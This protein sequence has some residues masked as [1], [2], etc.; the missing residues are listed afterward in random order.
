MPNTVQFRG[1]ER[2]TAIVTELSERR[3]LLANR[4]LARVAQIPDYTTG[5]IA[6]DDVRQTATESLRLLVESME[7]GRARQELLDFAGSLGARRA[8]QGIPPESL[9]SAVRLDF[10]IIWSDLLE[11]C[12]P[13]D[14]PLLTARVEHVWRVVDEYGTQAHTSYL[15]ERIRMAQEE[16]HFKQEFISRLFGPTG[17]SAD[18]AQTVA[19][20]LE[21]DAE[22]EFAIVAAVGEGAQALRAEATAGIRS[23]GY[24]LHQSGGMTFV[25]WQSA[26]PARPGTVPEAM[27]AA[28][29]PVACGLVEGIRG[30]RGVAAAGATASSLAQLL[31]D[32]DSGPLTIDRGWARF[33]REQLRA[34]GLDIAADV[35]RALAGCKLAER[36]RLEETVRAFIA[37]GSVS[38]TADVLFCHRNTILNRLHRFRELTGIDLTIPAQSARMVVAFS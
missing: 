21:V 7:E 30:L 5:L 18:V 38:D 26:R 31:T 37:S 17:Q 28:F 34:A 20:A 27:P 13:E 11:I 25:F 33:A 4:F 19:A 36:Q 24:F 22:G 29:R 32:T 6:E 16:S 35:E 8:R 9:I 10:S 12:G 14:A 1:G 15:A 3:V 2:W 23:K